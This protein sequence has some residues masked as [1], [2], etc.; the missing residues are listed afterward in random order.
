MTFSK[1]KK[2]VIACILALGIGVGGGYYFFGSPVNTQPTNVREQTKQTKPITET[3]NTYVVQAAKESGPAVVGITT[4]VFQKDIFNRTIYAGEGVGSGVLIDNDGH[5]ITNKHV[6]AG[7]RNGEVTVSLS[8]GSTVTGT[9]IGSDSQTDLAVVKIKP[10]KDIKPIK[11]G[12]SD[13]LQVGEPAIA[14][15]NPLG[16]EFKGSVTSG[17]ISAL[18]RTIDDQ[19]QRFPLIQTDAAINPGNSGFA[20]PINSAMTIVDSIIKNGKVIRP[21]IGVWA[22]D[23]QTAARNNVTYEGDGLLVVQ[24]DPNGPAAQ[25]GLVEGDT[26]AQIDGKDITTLLELKEQIDAKSPG[27]TILVS[28]T[29]NGKMKST[30]LKLGEASSN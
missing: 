2:T 7:A 16:L 6:V 5:I 20:I 9:V 1:Y 15:G 25:A 28:Y 10:P 21:Y 4:Q 13:S 8:D 18:A 26:I 3:R 23:R 19:G 30:Q 22:V 12:D 24:L 27:D 29:H 17:V 11:I 14:I